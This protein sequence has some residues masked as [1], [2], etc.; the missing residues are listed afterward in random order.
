MSENITHTAVV[1]DCL[2]LMAAD[3]TFSQAFK[4]AAQE[5]QAMTR[6]GCMTRAGDRCN[7]GLLAT[8]RERWATRLP[9]EHL[10][11][12][13]AF[14]LGWLCHRAADRQ[15]KP[16]F[17]RFHP[18]ETRTESPTEC[19]V[20]HDAF[21]FREVYGAGEA[22]PYHPAMFGEDFETL[23]DT[24][25]VADL[26]DL[27][28]VLLRRALIEMHTLIPNVDDPEAWIDHL[29][30]RRQEFYVD[31]ERYDAAITNPDP[32]KVQTYIIDDGFYERDDPIIDVARRLQHGEKVTP[33][34]VGGAID[35]DATSHYGQALKLGMKY[36]R[37]ADEF[38]TSDMDIE[39]LKV[40]LDIG[41][42][43]RDGLAV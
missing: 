36:L 41:K 13:L 16:I 21:I 24:I 40:R 2:R 35:A 9:E 29:F 17:R 39:T 38:F 32:E 4:E 33:E 1:D 28:H 30:T 34:E 5:H 23:S 15:M 10:E 37:A 43:G 6:L 14:V 27:V 31:L 25:N 11:P 8:F 26:Q 12:K 19:S 22:S 7:P 42:A 18:P 20:Y 3:E